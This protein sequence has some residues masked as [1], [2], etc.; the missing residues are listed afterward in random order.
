MKVIKTIVR[1]L[2]VLFKN[3]SSP[4]PTYNLS[5]TFNDQQ[6]VRIPLKIGNHK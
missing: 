5:Q 1:T 4:K 3:L 2:K 6:T